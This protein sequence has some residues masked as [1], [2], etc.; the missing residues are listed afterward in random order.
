[1]KVG[2]TYI[3]ISFGIIWWLKSFL[4]VFTFIIFVCTLNTRILYVRIITELSSLNQSLWNVNNLHFIMLWYHCG[5]RIALKL[6]IKKHTRFY[7]L[8]GYYDFINCVHDKTW[9]HAVHGLIIMLNHYIIVG[10]LDHYNR[11]VH[12]FIQPEQI[13]D[14]Y[15][16]THIYI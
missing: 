4:T 2:S 10:Y 3:I 8:G 5:K 16:G 15:I 9:V 7:I 14:K 13:Y 1:M 11:M 12:S 6:S